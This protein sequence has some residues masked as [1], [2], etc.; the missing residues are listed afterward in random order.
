MLHVS[1]AQGG[2]LPNDQT[3]LD[4]CSTVAA[5]KNDKFL[6]GLH[7]V[8]AGIKINGNAGAAVTNMKGKFGRLN[9]WYLPDGIAN[10]LSMHE[11]EKLY[12]ITYNSWEGFYVVHSPRG[13]VRFYKDKHGLLYIDLD[14]SGL[15]AARMLM[16]VSKETA[17][18]ELREVEAGLSCV[19]TVHG[20]YEGF[21]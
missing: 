3:Y 20:N 5:S 2:D 10:I 19:Q 16:Q 17:K 7:A 14:K 21:T 12:R 6:S 1:M 15:E 4:G 18:E 9:A 13:E 11:L 8:A